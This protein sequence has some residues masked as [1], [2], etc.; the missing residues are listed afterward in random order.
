MLL[1][2]FNLLKEVFVQ[3]P[4][5][6]I[7]KDLNSVYKGVNQLAAELLGFKKIDEL[8]GIADYDI[9]CEAA[10]FA[11]LAR[12]FDKLTISEKEVKTLDVIK[13]A[14]GKIWTLIDTKKLVFNKNKDPVGILCH[15]MPVKNENLTKIA[16]NLLKINQRKNSTSQI[17]CGIFSLT[18]EKYNHYR[19]SKQESFCLFFLVRGNT[20]KLIAKKMNISFRTVE[21]YLE[22]IKIKLNCKNKSELIAKAIE[23]GFLTTIPNA[24]FM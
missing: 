16:V 13:Y 9:R 7:F 5:L 22:N 18:N 19:L 2:D 1:N 11:G 21:S 24:G 17:E 12:D 4:G 20:A 10:I 14:D 15:A 3:F 6:V 8:I 23:E